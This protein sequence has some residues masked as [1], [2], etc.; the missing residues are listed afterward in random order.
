MFEG[1][2]S[3]VRLSTFVTGNLAN[4]HKS[5][6]KAL[7]EQCN[8]PAKYYFVAAILDDGNAVTFGGPNP[9][10]DVAIAKFFSKEK[11]GRYMR[12]QGSGK[13]DRSEKLP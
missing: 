1:H 7:R 6:D 5:V 13:P 11:F 2:L 9:I 12:R 3:Y 4:Q 10:P 8:I